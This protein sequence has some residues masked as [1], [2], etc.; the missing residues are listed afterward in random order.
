MNEKNNKMYKD[1]KKKIIAKGKEN[2]K[3]MEE[4]SSLRNKKRKNSKNRIKKTRRGKLSKGREEYA[5]KEKKM[6]TK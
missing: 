5:K 4:I 1:E 3:E 6:K 2:E